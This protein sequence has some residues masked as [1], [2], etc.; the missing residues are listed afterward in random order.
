MLLPGFLGLEAERDLVTASG[1][2]GVP[3]LLIL[4]A[5]SPPAAFVLLDSVLLLLVLF[6][7]ILNN[8]HKQH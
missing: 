6:A 1:L 3:S 7:V 8:K 4:A 5:L 2:G